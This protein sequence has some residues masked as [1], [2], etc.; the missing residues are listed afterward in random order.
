MPGGHQNKL[1]PTVLCRP[2]RRGC[3]RRA[4][5]QG[6]PLPRGLSPRL[7][8]RRPEGRGTSRRHELVSSQTTCAVSPLLPHDIQGIPP[9]SWKHVCSPECRGR[10]RC[11]G[12]LSR[13][14]FA[15][16]V[17]PSA[18]RSSSTP[19][20]LP[21]RWFCLVAVLADGILPAILHGRP[22]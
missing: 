13:W 20:G 14:I 17:A 2:G 12:V 9:E 8:Q 7:L 1:P 3:Q 21:I 18:T 4:V 22:T 10:E 6:S 19:G 15:P 16:Y 11:R 5:L